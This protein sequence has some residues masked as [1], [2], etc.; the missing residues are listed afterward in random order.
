MIVYEPA[1]TPL[2][3]LDPRSKLLAQVGFAVA[4]LG[5]S[6]ALGLGVLT[7]LALGTLAVARLPPWRVLRAYWFVLVVL[8]TAPVLSSLTLGPP[9]VVPER[10]VDPVIAGYQVLLVLCVSAAYVR[11]T[12][13]RETRAAIQRHV[14][15]RPGQ[16][17]GVG[18]GLVFRL[19]PLLLQDLQRAR[20]AV[21]ARSGEGLARTERARRLTRA[22]LRRAF[23]RAETLSVALR[24]RC[25]A[26][27]PT[28][29]RLRLSPPDYPLL[30]FAVVLAVSPV[31]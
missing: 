12:P 7:A 1:P 28:L 20:L 6:S 30:V 18:V 29:P 24:A 9:W 10:G 5:H 4:A 8:A 25:F 14:P 19:F 31:V 13:V 27:N 21:R 17:L 16:L 2:H 26:W 23:E 11:T 22:G 3:A 15:G